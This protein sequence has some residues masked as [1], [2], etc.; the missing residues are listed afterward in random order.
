MPKRRKGCGKSEMIPYHRDFIEPSVVERRQAIGSFPCVSLASENRTLML[1]K[2]AEKGQPSLQEAL[3]FENEDGK[4][5][6]LLAISDLD[7]KELYTP[8]SRSET[9]FA[10]PKPV[11]ELDWHAQYAEEGQTFDDYLRFLT[12]RTTG[13]IKP[14]ANAEG[15]DVFLLPIIRSNERSNNSDS[16]WPGGGPSLEQLVAYTRVF[17][18]RHVHILPAANL[19]V[20]KH[21]TKGIKHEKSNAKKKRKSTTN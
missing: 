4:K 8:T 6:Q 20:I 7:K 15:T 13:R 21:T 3:K 16:K 17:F 18:D 12:T 9:S 14:I 1:Q 10:I 5:V 2:S 11:D 19:Q